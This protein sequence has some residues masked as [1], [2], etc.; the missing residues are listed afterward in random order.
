MDQAIRA[1]LPTG[2]RV[3]VLPTVD[4][5]DGTSWFS[6][7]SPLRKVD[8]SGSSIIL[9]RYGYEYHVGPAATMTL[10]PHGITY[11]IRPG[12]TIPAD[13]AQVSPTEVIGSITR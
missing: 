11:Y 3:Y 4:V 7:V 12:Q 13:L 1:T 10:N 5:T 8:A 9:D 2:T 6:M